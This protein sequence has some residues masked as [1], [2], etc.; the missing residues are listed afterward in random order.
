MRISAL[1]K[2]AVL[3]LCAVLATVGSSSSA[4]GKWQER[5]ITPDEFRQKFGDTDEQ[6]SSDE[7]VVLLFKLVNEE[8]VRAG[9]NSLNWDNV[10]ARAG[11]EQARE[12][13]TN[14]YISHVNLDGYMPVW[15][16]NRAGGTNHVSENLTYWEWGMRAYLTEKLVEE[17]HRGWMDSEPHRK[18]I[19]NPLHNKVG[20]G[21][22]VYEQENKTIIASAQEFVD[23]YGEFERIP[24]RVSGTQRITLKGKL[25]QGYQLEGILVGYEPPPAPQKPEVLSSALNGYKLPEPILAIFPLDNAYTGRTASVPS[26]Y[27]LTYDRLRNKFS[28]EVYLATLFEEVRANAQDTPISKYRRLQ[29][30][31]K[32]GIYYFFITATGVN[33]G[34]F[35]VSSQAVELR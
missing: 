5:R 20:I 14:Q 24:R 23:S 31:P 12:M 34:A 15:R 8:R 27:L 22:Y 21:I 2:V 7:A 3:S 17:I 13:A 1:L 11:Y 9:L 6:I 10:A 18:N 25:N 4:E 32:P 33:G 28:V 35:I 16:Y 19:L 29:D 26:A 30:F